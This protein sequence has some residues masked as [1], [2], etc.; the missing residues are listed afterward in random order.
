MARSGDVDNYVAELHRTVESLTESKAKLQSHMLDQVSLFKAKLQGAEDENRSLRVA[1]GGSA[2][3]AATAGAGARG[4]S[5][6]RTGY[7]VAA[8]AASPPSGPGRIVVGA[9]HGKRAMP[10]RSPLCKDTGC[11]VAASPPPP[12]GPGWA[13]G[14]V[15]MVALYE[16][17]RA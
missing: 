12:S 6:P 3:A 8:A 11:G 14:R 4:R 15:R 5:P 17:A 7:G 2:A 10:G 16:G 9:G 1:L 13:E